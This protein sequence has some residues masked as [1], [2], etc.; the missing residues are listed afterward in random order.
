MK[1][2]ILLAITVLSLSLPAFA[3]S[4]TNAPALAKYRAVIVQCIKDGKKDYS[5]NTQD[6]AKIIAEEA[7][8]QGYKV[9]VTK[10]SDGVQITLAK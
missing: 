10:L 8:K 9:K 3:D 6:K 7:A 2:Q 5:A 4:V 1:K